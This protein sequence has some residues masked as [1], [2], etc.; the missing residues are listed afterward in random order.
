MSIEA[1]LGARSAAW[2]SR[3]TGSRALGPWGSSLR[4]TSSVSVA[5]VPLRASEA[6]PQVRLQYW[7][8]LGADSQRGVLLEGAP[9]LDR[10]A[11]GHRALP[12][13]F[14]GGGCCCARARGRLIGCACAWSSRPYSYG[15][16]P[17]RHTF[18]GAD[19]PR[20][21]RTPAGQAAEVA[22]DPALVS[23]RCNRSARGVHVAGSGAVHRQEQWSGTRTSPGSEAR[24]D[25][26]RGAVAAHWRLAGCSLLA[27]F[28]RRTR[29][30]H[31]PHRG[32]RQPRICGCR[33][34]PPA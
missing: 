16:V 13:A 28:R 30:L 10:R 11:D 6:V 9:D 25:R 32:P 2:T 27:R 34:R 8:A 31:R 3:L 22:R 14:V 4:G 26:R 19:R 7:P 33:D 5:V 24:R 15:S 29:A 21:A 17:C 1:V 12:R 23:D 20:P 18:D